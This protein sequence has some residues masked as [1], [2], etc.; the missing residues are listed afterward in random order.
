MD[1]GTRFFGNEL[2][3]AEL[4]A[5]KREECDVHFDKNHSYDMARWFIHNK[6]NIRTLRNVCL[7]YLNIKRLKSKLVTTVIS[8]YVIIITPLKLPVKQP[9]HSEIYV[10]IKHSMQWHIFVDGLLLNVKVTWF[11][12]ICWHL[13]VI[14]PNRVAR[15]H[16]FVPFLSRICHSL[17]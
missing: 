2:S 10:V 4:L 11:V 16:Y 9:N 3:L 15:Q 17:R 5:N 6:G 13:R 7:K 8:R 1:P 14:K 12:I